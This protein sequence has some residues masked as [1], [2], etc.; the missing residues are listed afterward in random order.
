MPV[1]ATIGSTITFVVEFLDNNSVLTVPS[2][3]TLTVLYPIGVT[4]SSCVIGMVQNGSFFT[5]SWGSGVSNL[6]LVN[7]LVTAPGQP[8]VFGE[9]LRL[10]S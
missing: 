5:A 10:T 4:V 8:T 2:S 9:P 6:G 3:A 1:N 7:Y